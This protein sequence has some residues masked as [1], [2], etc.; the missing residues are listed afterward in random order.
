MEDCYADLNGIRLHYIKAGAGP[1]M[2]FLHGFPEFSYAWNAQL[3]EFAKDHLVVAPDMRGYNLSAK[4]AQVDQYAM[5]NLVGDIRALADHL[6]YKKFVLVA[7]DWGGVVAWAFAIRFPE[8]LSELISINAPHPAVF[9]K[10][11]RENA[12]QQKASSYIGA[13]QNPGVEN[14]LAA[15]NFAALRQAMAGS[16][17]RPDVFSDPDWQAYTAAWSQPGALTG[18]LNYYRVPRA[19]I[20]DGANFKVTVPTLVLW[21]E[22][23]HALNILNV[24]GLPAYVPNLTV[25][26]FPSGTHWVVH[27]HPTEINQAIRE[28]LAFKTQ[29]AAAR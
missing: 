29:N 26:R 1:L 23:D 16:A 8:L 21:G 6:G 25:Q 3:R 2:I 17:A 18:M 10:L 22:K 27:E 14:Y 28:F 24:D 5:P 7:H 13:F 15:D 19:A 11:L 12:D 20:P 9:A 4:P